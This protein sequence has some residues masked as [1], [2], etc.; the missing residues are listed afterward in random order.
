MNT[1]IIG[2]LQDALNNPWMLLFLAVWG[3]GYF[4]KEYTS[5][6]SK[7]TPWVILPFGVI[8]GVVLIQQSVGGAIVGG[9]MALAQMGLY[10]VVKPLVGAVRDGK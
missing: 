5:L 2:V 1:E 4:V 9:L 3:L 8:L 10:D 7:K 6:D